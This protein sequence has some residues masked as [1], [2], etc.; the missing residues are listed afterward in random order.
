M[1][2]AQKLLVVNMAAEQMRSPDFISLGIMDRYGDDAR[3][4]H[5]LATRQYLRDLERRH[6]RRRDVRLYAGLAQAILAAASFPLVP[7]H[8]RLMGILLYS[9][10]IMQCGGRAWTSFRADMALRL[11]KRGRIFEFCMRGSIY[12]RAWS[13]VPNTLVTPDAPGV[14]MRH[15][16]R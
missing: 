7:M 15:D 1:P 16:S 14:C 5:L 11:S 3:R 9:H 13:R 10:P 8:I 6:A 4:H 2:R 12:I